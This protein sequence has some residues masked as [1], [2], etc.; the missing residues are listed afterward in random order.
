MK[1]KL[2]RVVAP[3][4]VA[5]VVIDAGGVVIDAAPI[6]RYCKGKSVVWTLTLCA[7]KG[8]E[9]RYVKVDRGVVNADD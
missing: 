7:R 5:G 3:H 1:L 4:F 9:A 2:L 6:L 8:W